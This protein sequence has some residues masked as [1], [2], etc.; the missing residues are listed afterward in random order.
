MRTVHLDRIR[1][2]GAHIDN[3]GL[4][5]GSIVERRCSACLKCCTVQCPRILRRNIKIPDVDLGRLAKDDAVRIDDVDV[6]AALNRTV[7][8]RGVR[9]RNDVQIVVGLIPAVIAHTFPLRDGVI[10]PCN[11]IIGV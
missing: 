9:T 6:L 11:H 1:L 10:S 4:Q 7:D 5:C 2:D 3:I 8:I